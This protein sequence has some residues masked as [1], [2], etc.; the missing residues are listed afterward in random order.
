MTK[1]LTTLADIWDKFSL[2]A[3]GWSVLAVIAMLTMTAL[4]LT[5]LTLWRNYTKRNPPIDDEFRS[6]QKIL[7]DL[8][9]SLSGLAPNEKVD[10]LVE[11]LGNFATRE[12]V[13][14]IEKLLPELIKREELER[15][16][17][18]IVRD[19]DAQMKEMRAYVHDEV[20]KLRNDLQNMDAT[21]Q[22]YRAGVHS[23]LGSITEV[24][25]E[26]RG[27]MR[28]AAEREERR[29]PNP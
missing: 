28:G 19:S 6:Q 15:C 21:S 18:K 29:Y 16:L 24:L 7:D 10:K 23:R 3:L 14:A 20:H 4:V 9:H 11:K 27:Q 1:G 26:M 25:Y 22:L 5:V 17:D 2:T 13:I 8:R 12:D